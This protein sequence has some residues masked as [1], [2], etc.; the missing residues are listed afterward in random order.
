MKMILIQVCISV[1]LPIIRI[2]YETNTQYREQQKL[3][4]C[5]KKLRKLKKLKNHKLAL[6]IQI[7]KHSAKAALLAVTTNNQRPQNHIL[8]I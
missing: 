3:I 2:H 7:N 5:D 1:V 8:K 6:N 4:Q